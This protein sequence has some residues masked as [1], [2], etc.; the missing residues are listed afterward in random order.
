MSKPTFPS[1]DAGTQSWDAQ[2][3]SWQDVLANQGLPLVSYA[4][5]TAWDAVKA[6]R[7]D[8]IAK[9]ATNDDADYTGPVIVYGNAGATKKVAWQASEV[10]ELTDN[11][12]GTANDTL[13]ALSDP[14]DTPA[15]ADVLRDDLVA[16]LIPE[17]RNNYA[18]LAAKVNSIIAALKNTG[19][20]ASA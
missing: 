15:T 11:T 14:A 18:D 6:L 17:L 13:Q 12:T 3:A 4:N 2:L 7:D 8:T 5:F 10:A 16:N 19:G 20:M 9:V 1:V